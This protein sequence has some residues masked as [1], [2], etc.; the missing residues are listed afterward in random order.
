MAVG[1]VLLAGLAGLAIRASRG[2]GSP[3]RIWE[4]AQASLRAERIGEAQ[5]ALDRLE[6]L[7]PP[8]PLDRMLRAQVALAEG[9]L[10]AALEALASVPDDHPIAAQARLMAGQV[11]LRRNRARVA[12]RWFREAIHL[13]PNLVQARRELIYILGYQLRR[14]E[15]DAQFEAIAA[16]ADL[17]FE[18]VFHW[19]LLHTAQWEPASAIEGLRRFIEADPEDRWSR[20]ALAENYRRSGLYQEASDLLE[21]LP[22]TD[23]EALANR[24]MVLLDRHQEQEAER[25]LAQA[26]DDSALLCR[27][28]GRVALAHRDGPAAA[29]HFGRAERLDPGNRDAI[30]GL[31]NALTLIGDER[32]GEPLRARARRIDELNSLMERAAAP[33]SRSNIALLRDLGAACAALGRLP[34][35]RAWYKLALAVEPLDGESQRALYRLQ[36]TSDQAASVPS[37]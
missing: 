15:L 32:A 2:P 37:T 22:A 12:E 21:P 14:A 35:A 11:E 33:G 29:G 8:T 19:G 6:R 31:I 10:E 34:E 26:P 30:F 27:L 3:D 4:D 17:P 24:V 18:N 36:T 16:V 7:R 5:V 23:P 28:K 20:L 1:G 25:L 9:R 13:D